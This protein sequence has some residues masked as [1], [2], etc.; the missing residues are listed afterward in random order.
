[1]KK[2]PTMLLLVMV[3]SGCDSIKRVK[4]F[5]KKAVESADKVESAVSA[6][7]GAVH[8]LTADDF[9]RFTEQEGSLVVVDFYADWCGPCKMLAPMLEELALEYGDRVMVGKLDVDAYGE[10]SARAG[11]KGIP[12]VRFF[13]NGKQVDKLVGLPPE[14]VLRARFE[15]HMD[16]TAESVEKE[17]EAAKEEP[18]Q[19]KK[20]KE[21][22]PPAKP[23][24]PA[25]QP[26][27]KDWMPPGM[28]RRGKPAGQSPLRKQ[29]SAG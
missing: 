2:L 3:V 15:K 4:E 21:E 12:D 10:V 23:R 18:K 26:M 7:G 6:G 8:H 13:R 9:V 1:M 14:R 11:V 5:G 24:E 22:T 17:V 27:K 28:E 29:D 25:I 20:S 19:Q 16:D